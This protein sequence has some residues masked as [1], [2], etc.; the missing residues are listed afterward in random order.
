MNNSQSNIT[1]RGAID[2]GEYDPNYLGTFPEWNQLSRHIQFQY[3][4]TAIDN[5]RKQ[6]TMQYA[7]VN[8]I[9]DFSKKPHLTEA[10]KNIEKQLKIIELDRERLFVEYSK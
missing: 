4:K 9:L 10:L 6:L 7:E 1:L 8:N 3:I 5:R 2:L